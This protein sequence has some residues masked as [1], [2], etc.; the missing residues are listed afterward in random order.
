M[1]D[2]DHHDPPPAAEMTDTQLL[3]EA[4][5]LATRPSHLDR[6][7]LD[8]LRSLQVNVE[9]RGLTKALDQRVAEACVAAAKL[10]KRGAA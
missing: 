3:D 9:R 6:A 10:V 5:A 2:T 8:R 4:V 1:P 7:D